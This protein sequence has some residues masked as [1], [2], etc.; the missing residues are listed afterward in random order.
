MQ[1][2]GVDLAAEP[3]N[4]ALATIEWS[5]GRA[6]VVDVQVGV[7]DNRI[8]QAAET[9]AKIGI[10]CPLGWPDTFVQFLR[11]FH[12]GSYVTVP[13]GADQKWRKS[14]ANRITDL[15]VQRKLKLTPLSVATDRIGLTAMRAAS[16]QSLLAKA[17][18]PVDRTGSGLLVEVYP[19]A[20]MV[21]W[22]LDH[23]KYKGSKN[24]VALGKLVDQLP[25][26]LILGDHESLCRKSDHAL[27]AVI[28]A[29]LARAAALGLTRP[30]SPEHLDAATREGWIALPT[31]EID[32]LVHPA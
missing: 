27:D 25:K 2:V 12:E 21:H 23:R 8:L 4:T 31:C 13:P 15:E 1:T 16:I 24:E 6:Q 20:G 7:D 14:L 5:E 18:Y 9:A 30:P 22:H 3:K 29:L 19:A 26:R 11:D 17:G 10:D 28:A 32:A